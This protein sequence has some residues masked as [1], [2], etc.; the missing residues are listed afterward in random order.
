MI[1]ITFTKLYWLILFVAA[2]IIYTSQDLSAGV[3]IYIFIFGI[4]FIIMFYSVIMN[5]SHFM[6]KE[7]YFVSKAIRYQLIEGGNH[8]KNLI[9][10]RT[11]SF[12][13]LLGYSLIF[14]FLFYIYGVF[15]LF[16]NGCNEEYWKSCEKD[17]F[18]PIFEKNSTSE[19]V[20]ISTSYILG[21]Y[22]NMQEIGVLSA[23]WKHLLFSIL[24]ALDVYIQ[25]IEYFFFIK[26]IRNRRDYRILS[27]KNVGLKAIISMDKMKIRKKYYI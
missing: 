3:F 1:I 6:Q 5:L 26:N 14:I 21:F 20:I 22:I 23:S 25:K 19:N 15:D 9:H 11:I 13:F 16:Q 12:R 8:F 18:S 4:T 27:N 17:H 10:H 2:G 24:V 7:T